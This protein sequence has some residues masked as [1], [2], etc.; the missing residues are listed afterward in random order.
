MDDN[1]NNKLGPNEIVQSWHGLFKFK[2]ESEGQKGLRSPQIGALHA[3]MAHIEDGEK[4]AIVVMPT[5]T[6]KTETMLA[7]MVANL[8]QKVFVIVPSDALRTQTYKKFKSL[9]LLRK[10]GIIPQ[11]INLPI[12]SMVSTTLDD[13]QWK[14]RI[15]E[16]NVII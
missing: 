10:L 14:Q 3:L 15:N 2:K 6:G 9:G 13:T 1:V 5:G 16:S 8:C 7:F 12:V 11:D 4:T